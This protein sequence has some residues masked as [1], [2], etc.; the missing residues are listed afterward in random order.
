MKMEF[1]EGNGYKLPVARYQ[2]RQPNGKKYVTR[3][4]YHITGAAQ[5]KAILGK[6]TMLYAIIK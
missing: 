2:E 5:N 4:P 1:A 3:P 6:H